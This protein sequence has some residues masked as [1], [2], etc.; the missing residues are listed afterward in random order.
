M[1]FYIVVIGEDHCPLVLLGFSFLNTA[2]EEVVY[3]RVNMHILVIKLI[4]TS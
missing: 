4:S 1:R 3:W 2:I